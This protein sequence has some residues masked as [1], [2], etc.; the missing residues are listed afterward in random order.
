LPLALAIGQKMQSKTYFKIQNLKPI[1][2]ANGNSK[3]LI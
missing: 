3:I 2:K 1:A